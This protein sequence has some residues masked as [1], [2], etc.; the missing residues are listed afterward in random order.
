[1]PHFMP[2]LRVCSCLRWP[3]GLGIS[4]KTSMK[5]RDCLVDRLGGASWMGPSSPGMC[6]LLCNTTPHCSPSLLPPPRR[7]IIVIICT[8][9]LFSLPSGWH[10][11]GGG[12]GSSG[13]PSV[14]S[15]ANTSTHEQPSSARSQQSTARKASK[16]VGVCM[17][18]SMC[19]G[20]IV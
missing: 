15:E 18:L 6:A 13:P 17:C 14:R 9:S 5:Q 11:L 7:R 10:R 2:L 12:P 4:N 8:T 16:Y 20:L 3:R 19:V 1:M